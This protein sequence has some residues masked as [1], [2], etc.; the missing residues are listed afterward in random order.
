[1]TLIELELEINDSTRICDRG[2]EI[3]DDAE[4]YFDKNLSEDFT[5]DEPF[6]DRNCN[7]NWD[8]AELEVEE[9]SECPASTVFIEDNDGTKFCDRGN[10]KYDFAEEFIDKNNNTDYDEGS[11]DELLKFRVDERPANFLVSYDNYPV[12]NEPRKLLNIYQGD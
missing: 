11:D 1:M 9:A 8:D 2:N 5:G 6:E 12:L 3:W 7:G 10:N 4:V